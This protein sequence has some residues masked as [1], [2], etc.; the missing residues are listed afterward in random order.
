MAVE[1]KQD[2]DSV[3][4]ESDNK[5]LTTSERLELVL[6][7]QECRARTYTKLRDA[8]RSLLNE[9]IN[10]EQYLEK[11]QGL[12]HEF[13][14]VSTTMREQSAQF[15][16]KNLKKLSRFVSK[17]QEL[18]KQKLTITMDMQQ[19][20]LAARPPDDAHSGHQCNG[21]HHGQHG[22]NGDNVIWRPR[23]YEEKQQNALVIEQIN[24][25]LAEI[26]EV[27]DSLIMSQHIVVQGTSIKIQ[28][29]TDCKTHDIK[30]K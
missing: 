6:K 12:M 11:V 19:K 2:T 26:K 3:V 8:F 18:E 4:V 7:T 20:I 17:L 23:L 24:E 15:T 10:D 9:E 22:K 14:S 27:R 30:S 5:K 29:D 1:S 13:Q 16:K 21:H 25:L 28:T